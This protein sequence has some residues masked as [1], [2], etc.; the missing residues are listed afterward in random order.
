MKAIKSYLL[1]ALLASVFIGCDLF[2]PYKL[3]DI[4][5]APEI[6]VP[7]GAFS[8][9]RDRYVYFSSG[10]LQYHAG[11]DKWRFAPNQYDYVGEGNSNI[12]SS[13]NGWIDLFGWGTGDSP[14]KSSDDYNDYSMFIDWG[15]NQ[16]GNDEEGT[17]RTLTSSE[18]E[19]ILKKR[20]NASSLQGLAR[21]A[22]VNGFI[23][24]P[25]NWK[26]PSGVTFNLGFGS[27][28]SQNIYSV[29]KWQL[30]EEAG[31]IFLPA[32][33]Y[34]KKDYSW[35]TGTFATLIYDVGSY[36]YYWSSSNSNYYDEGYCLC[37]SSNQ[38]S[39]MIEF[40]YCG[41]CIRLVR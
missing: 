21:V 8:V 41:C 14:T 28:F 24:L 40:Y 1:L 15:A 27:G 34:R 10:N 3:E 13:Y 7:E 39:M 31:A 36:G 29:S 26:R 32:A 2:F 23:L 4:P 6:Q 37:F 5:T 33:G 25:D 9:A 30:M 16:I 20:K 12:S 19:Y 38:A 17:W 35:I 18:W 11:M 22:D